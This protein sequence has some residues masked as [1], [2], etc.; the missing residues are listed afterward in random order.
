[1]PGDD[2]RP[3]RG[4]A[5]V[6]PAL[7]PSPRLTAIVQELLAQGVPRIIVVNDGSEIGRAHV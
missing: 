5:V 1:M 7:D 2:R 6:I 3:E 4:C